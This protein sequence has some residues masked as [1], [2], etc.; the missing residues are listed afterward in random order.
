MEPGYW[1]SRLEV[2]RATRP[3]LLIT[4]RPD[5]STG[6]CEIQEIRFQ[7]HDGVRLWGL[8]GRCSLFRSEQPAVLRIVGACQL[9]AVDV[10]SVQ[11]GNTEFVIQVPAGRKLED[12]VLDALRLA[13]LAA[14]FE[15]VD[16]SRV[17]FAAGEPSMAPDEVLIAIKLR[18]GGLA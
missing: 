9:P 11:Q 2:Q 5:L 8:M 1:R 12:R 13:E 16:P 4:P 14:N 18:L 15:Q 6:G 10:A 17:G 7:A 3:F